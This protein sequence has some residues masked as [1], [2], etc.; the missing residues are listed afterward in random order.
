M[1]AYP[2]ASVLSIASDVNAGHIDDTIAEV[3][4]EMERLC[5]TPVGDDELEMVRNYMMGE[6]MRSFDGPFY[7]SDARIYLLELGLPDDF[8]ARS[9]EALRTVTAHDLREVARR[10]YDPGKLRV[11]I[12]GKIA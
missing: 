3:R 5:D 2:D 10:Y 7:A 9:V 6:L 1:T 4:N 11:A 12:A 8:Y